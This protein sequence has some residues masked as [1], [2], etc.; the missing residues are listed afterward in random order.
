MIM[1]TLSIILSAATLP[2]ARAAPWHKLHARQSN[3]NGNDDNN[4]GNNAGIPSS[5][6]VCALPSSQ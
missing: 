3:G 1:S 4:N 2:I 5:I 6:W